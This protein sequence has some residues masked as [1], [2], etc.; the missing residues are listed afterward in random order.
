MDI[1]PNQ[2]EL[3]YDHIINSFGYDK[4]AYVLA[5]TTVAEK[6]AID[7]IARALAKR[8][9]DKANN[10]YSLDKVKDIKNM[11]ETDPDRAREKYRNYSITLM[12]L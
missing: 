7:D 10:P 1:A 8:Y 3:V 5:I 12:V 2:R 9:K 11:Y 4:T 6:G